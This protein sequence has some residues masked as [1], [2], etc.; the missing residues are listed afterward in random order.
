[1][2]AWAGRVCHWRAGGPVGG[3][4]RGA[5]V[6]RLILLG[7]MRKRCEGDNGGGVFNFVRVGATLRLVSGLF[8]NVGE[9]DDLHH[10]I[11]TVWALELLLS[12]AGVHVGCRVLCRLLSVFRAGLFVPQYGEHV[13]E[14]RHAAGG[15]LGLAPGRRLVA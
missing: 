14:R 8:L 4:G 2:A 15:N 3:E 12:Q 10:Y 11:A 1:M 5:V 13:G 6:T 9:P 7:R